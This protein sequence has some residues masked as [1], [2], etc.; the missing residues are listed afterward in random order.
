M[1]PIKLN[2]VK[3]VIEVKNHIPLLASTVSLRVDGNGCSLTVTT[4]LEGHSAV[5]E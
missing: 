2:T 1:L 3:L 4:V 5:G